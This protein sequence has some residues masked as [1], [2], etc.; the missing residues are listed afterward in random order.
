MP[1]PADPDS[2]APDTPS[3]TAELWVVVERSGGF[4]GIT[5][6]WTVAPTASDADR[7]RALID[8]CPWPPS[9]PERVDQPG[10]GAD[11]FSWSVTAA[12]DDERR[13]ADLPEQEVDGPWRALIDAVREERE[14]TGSPAESPA[15]S[16][17]ESPE[18][19]A[20][21]PESPAEE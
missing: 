18:D 14:R 17:A 13:R 11:R 6:R 1:S 9:P 16:P 7:W 10:V 20:V 4:A 21:P 5:R 2:G 15:G 8:A 3:A 12:C 19:G